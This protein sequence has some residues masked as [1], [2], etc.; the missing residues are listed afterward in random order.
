[1]LFHT[2]LIVDDDESM[3]HM[4]T[5][6]LKD[7]GYE[8]RGVA[9]AEEALKELE[10]RDFD[11]VLSDVRMPKMDGIALL[12][13]IHRRQPELTVVVMSAYG[14]TDTAIEAMKEGAYDYISKP[15]KPDEVVL[16]L[17]KAEERERLKRENLRLRDE[18]KSA[19]R[20]D[21]LVGASAVMQE[22]ARQIRKVAA[23]K[24]T[25]LVTGESGTGKEL[26]A[27]ALHDLSP[28]AAMP[29]V[30]VNC[31][32][33]PGELMET[34]LFGHVRGAFTDAVRNKKG[35]FAEAD[36]GTIFLD[37]VG[38]L[39]QPLQ[40]KL[41]R[42]LQD[43]EIRRVGDSHSDKVDVKVIAAT[44][45]DLPQAVKAG[46]F[47][48]DLFYRLNVLNL[49]LPPLRER[50]GDIEALATHFIAKYNLRLSRHVKGI[51]PDAQQ[52]L[53]DYPWPGNVRELENAIERAMVLCEGESITVEGL[54]E[55]MVAP[56]G[57]A[58]PPGGQG[59]AAPSDLSIKKAARALEEDL[60][61]RA[62]QKTRGNRTRAA[63]L[64]EISHRALLYKIKEYGVDPDAEGAKGAA[65]GS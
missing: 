28:R 27:R 61:R 63:E 31:G 51:A 21:S 8:A 46:L 3:R 2:V 22:V 58:S 33:I 18:L 50:K 34:E 20:L 15:F 12:K 13:E 14:T 40:V 42:V 47:R 64:L 37:E 24:T 6:I 59:G 54:P 57:A 25:V 36:G 56:G 26:V 55:L 29:F 17:R 65:A 19:F 5:V 30:A 10:A 48:E 38:E 35:L 16:V 9:G 11:V 1:M 41:L 39:P 45:R 53:V 62:L 60:I 43:E 23:V 52:L 44:V 4:L 7:R 49:R 32:A